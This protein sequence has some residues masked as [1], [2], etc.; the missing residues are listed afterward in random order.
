MTV[1]GDHLP[2]MDHIKAPV[3]LGELELMHTFVVVES[4]VSPLILGLDIMHES[5]RLW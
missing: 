2:I 1:S 5:V 4:P 3:Q